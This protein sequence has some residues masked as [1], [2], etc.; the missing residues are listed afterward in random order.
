MSVLKDMSNKVKKIK[1]DPDRDLLDVTGIFNKNN[2][3]LDD[4]EEL[5]LKRKLR[6]TK[7]QLAIAEPINPGLDT[8]KPK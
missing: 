3:I 8:V 4:K 6:D 7:E 1:I 5:Q 2:F